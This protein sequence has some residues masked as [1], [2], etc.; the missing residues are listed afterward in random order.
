MSRSLDPVHTLHSCT[1]AVLV[2]NGIY[3]Y[4][5][6]PCVHTQ[7]IT[8]DVF[9]NAL[10]LSLTNS[11]RTWHANTKKKKPSGD[12]YFGFILQ[13][14]KTPLRRAAKNLPIST[15]GDMV[16]RKSRQLSARKAVVVHIQDKSFDSFADNMIKLSLNKQNR[17]V[18][19]LGPAL[20]FF[21]FWFDYLVSGSKSY[22]DFRVKATDHHE[23]KY[24]FGLHETS[25]T[26]AG[27]KIIS[28]LV[29][30]A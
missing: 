27:A 23:Q 20:F 26:G 3:F 14:E 16:S 21:R 18:C 19:Q 4:G 17:L 12:L 24:V 6:F 7:E 2:W 10:K 13:R 8:T 1:N 5:S 30:S 11:S 29:F 25:K 9:G 22:R 28:S 15:L